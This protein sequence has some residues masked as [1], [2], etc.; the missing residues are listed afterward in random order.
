MIDYFKYKLI[1]KNNKSSDKNNESIDKNPESI[2]KN[3]AKNI[4]NT[5]M[6]K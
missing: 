4:S 1:T 6:D 2:N 3:N 5:D